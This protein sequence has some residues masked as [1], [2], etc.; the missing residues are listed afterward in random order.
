M[1]WSPRA[2]NWFVSPTL[3]RSIGDGCLGTP[4]KLPVRPATQGLRDTAVRLDTAARRDICRASREGHRT[5]AA[6]RLPMVRDSADRP[7]PRRNAEC[8]PRKF[9]RLFK[10]F[11]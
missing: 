2:W 10:R 8:P 6:A 1:T 7:S 9:V 5:L 3:E 4:I 11:L